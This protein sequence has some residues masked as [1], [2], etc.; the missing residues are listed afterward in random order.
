MGCQNSHKT[1]KQEP[2][3]HNKNERNKKRGSISVKTEEEEE[4]KKKKRKKKEKQLDKTEGGK[5]GEMANNMRKQ[6]VR[7][8][9]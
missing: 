8:V 5:L 4:K 7:T 2:H 6:L 1:I 9:S 3:T